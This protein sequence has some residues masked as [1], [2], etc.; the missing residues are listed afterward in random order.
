MS[1]PIVIVSYTVTVFKVEPEV[2]ALPRVGLRHQAPRELF[3]WASNPRR[4]SCASCWQ[5][6]RTWKCP[7][8]QVPRPIRPQFEKAC[9]ECCEVSRVF[10]ATALTICAAAPHPFSD[11]CRKSP[12][13]NSS[14]AW[15]SKCL[16]ASLY[17]CV[18]ACIKCFLLNAHARCR[19]YISRYD[20]SWRCHTPLNDSSSPR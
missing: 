6:Q 1:A 9:N 5:P 14:L 18:W 11:A 15:A 16:L 10:S 20:M 19:H 2:Q 13:A 3:R 17:F 4:N 7:C 12:T 8:L